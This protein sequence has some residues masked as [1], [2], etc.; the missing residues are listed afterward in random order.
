MQAIDTVATET[1]PPISLEFGRVVAETRL[2]ATL[3][4]ALNGL[5]DRV[6][7][8]DM[9]WVVEAIEIHQE[10]GGDLAEVLDRVA[11]TIRARQRARRQVQTLSAEGRISAVILTSLPFAVGGLVMI[12]TPSYAED[13]YQTNAGRIMLVVAGALLVVGGLWLRRI[14][15]PEF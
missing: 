10:I 1:E 14:I 2:G 5:A 12:S 6:E 7:S 3:D 13:L 8:P 9:R 4:D 15:K 11:E